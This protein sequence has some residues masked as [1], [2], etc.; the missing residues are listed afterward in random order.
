MGGQRRRYE[1]LGQPSQKRRAKGSAGPGQA[2]ASRPG[3]AHR[4]DHEK[5]W[6]QFEFRQV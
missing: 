4:P 2:P 6:L 5:R 3:S 1:R